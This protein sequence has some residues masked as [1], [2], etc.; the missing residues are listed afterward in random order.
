MGGRFATPTILAGIARKAD[1]DGAERILALALEYSDKT[2][3]DLERVERRFDDDPKRYA[4]ERA[5]AEGVAA[6]WRGVVSGVERAIDAFD[7]GVGVAETMAL[8]WEVGIDYDGWEDDSHDF[9]L[10][11]RIARNDSILMGKREAQDVLATLKE[12]IGDGKGNPIPEGYRLAYIEWLRPHR[13]THWR[14]SRS[15]A[16]MLGDLSAFH[17]PLYEMDRNGWTLDLG[18]SLRLGAVKPRLH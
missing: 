7:I 2:M 16:D 17:N 15:P 5:H 18:R 14:T 4:V 11:I 3:R 13:G 8:E 1:G 12:N 9:D 10:N 6:Q